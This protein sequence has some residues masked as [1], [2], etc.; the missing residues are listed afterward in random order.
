[1]RKVTVNGRIYYVTRQR[2]ILHGLKNRWEA[3]SQKFA[4]TDWF[5]IDDD[6]TFDGLVKKLRKKEKCL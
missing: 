4:L 3:F 1:M 5:F 6:K 2:A